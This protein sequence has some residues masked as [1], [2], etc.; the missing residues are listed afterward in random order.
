MTPY[1]ST[2]IKAGFI[3][4]IAFSGVYDQTERLTLQGQIT[5]KMPWNSQ[6]RASVI[7]RLYIQSAATP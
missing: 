6:N 4:I 2:A 7:L 5:R 3:N 1:R